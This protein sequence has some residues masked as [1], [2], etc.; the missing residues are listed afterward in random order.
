MCEY[1]HPRLCCCVP[2][3]PLG[4][5]GVEGGVFRF[6]RMRFTNT[7]DAVGKNGTKA[8]IAKI[9]ICKPLSMVT[10]IFTHPLSATQYIRPLIR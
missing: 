9:L 7:Y 5:M 6:D 8:E 4:L 2:Y 10:F 3:R 1:P